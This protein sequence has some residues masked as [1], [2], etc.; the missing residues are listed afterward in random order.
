MPDEETPLN[1]L[2]VTPSRARQIRVPKTFAAMKH[3]NFQLYFGG[4]L[5]SVAGT[6]MQ[7]I[8]QGWVV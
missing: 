5:V 2:Q 8:A 1:P 6:W 3:R 7:I 4:Q